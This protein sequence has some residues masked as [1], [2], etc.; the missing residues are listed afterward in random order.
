M[1]RPECVQEKYM[2]STTENTQEENNDKL[3]LR[4]K[5]KRIKYKAEIDKTRGGRRDFKEKSSQNQ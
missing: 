5:E 4:D 3:G 1:W 2:V